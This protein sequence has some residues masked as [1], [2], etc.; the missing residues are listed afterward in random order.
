MSARSIRFDT[1][2]LG[3]GTEFRAPLRV[4]SAWNAEDVAPLLA[5][6]DG[7]RRAGYW[8]AGHVAYEAGYALTAKLAD[9]M[10]AE[11]SGPLMQFGVFDA[12]Q[13]PPEHSAMLPFGLGATVPLWS[14]DEYRAR[15]DQVRDYI[16]AGDIYQ[17]NLTFPFK[18]ELYGTPEA[19]YAALLH[20]QPVRYGAYVDLGGPVILSRSPELFF[21]CDAS[22]S[23]TARPMKGTAPRGATA[24][25]D[26]AQAAWLQSS[27]KNRA[28]NL[29]IV[30]LLRNDLGRIARIGSVAVPQ[31]FEIET[32]ATLHQMTSTVTAELR[33]GVTLPELIEALFPCGSITGAP[34]IRAMQILA[35]LE[36]GPRGVYCG[37]IGW[38]AP[39]GAMEFNVAIRTVTCHED[40]TVRFDVGGGI[41]YDSTAEAEYDEALLKARFADIA[42]HSQ[43]AE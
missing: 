43:A 4:L 21:R 23:L 24:E 17:A 28:E 34:K 10:P 30:D 1:G 22:G 6:M 5:E 31:L 37:S 40:G 35:E 14:Q 8:L 32:Y 9:A 36:A 26:T 7:W 2:P 42:P 29:M 15:F 38:I 11:R 27:E 33:E 13:A 25:G 19:L 16:A 18:T 39:D 20:H 12:P 3:H 41:V